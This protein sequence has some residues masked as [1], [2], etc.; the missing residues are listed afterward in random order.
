MIIELM[1]V[2]YM[3]KN[4]NNTE[5]MFSEI[6]PGIFLLICFVNLLQMHSIQV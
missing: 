3:L 2:K 4:S 1:L 5:G 6:Q